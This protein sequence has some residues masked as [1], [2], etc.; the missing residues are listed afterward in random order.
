MLI[1]HFGTAPAITCNRKW[2]W[3]L[4]QLFILSSYLYIFLLLTYYLF[5]I[6]G[7]SGFIY[8]CSQDGTNTWSML[9]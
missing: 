7:L 6:C 3:R 9:D 5:I 1:T 2:Q 8:I 4:E